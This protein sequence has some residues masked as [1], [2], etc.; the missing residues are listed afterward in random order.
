MYNYNN[1]KND[2]K[3]SGMI[4]LFSLFLVSQE[5]RSNHALALLNGT[6]AGKVNF[7]LHHADQLSV[8]DS[9]P[10]RRESITIIRKNEDKEVKMQMENG[11]IKKLEIDGKEISPDE[12]S[13]HEEIT[14]EI[15]IRT[16]RD[17]PEGEQKMFF[18][19]IDEEGMKWQ[20][21][22]DIRWDTI[23]EDF[24]LR[25]L[26][27]FQFDMKKFQDEMKMLR[28]ELNNS[29]LN[30]FFDMDTMSMDNA[31][32]MKMRFHFPDGKEMDPRDR[33]FEFS[34]PESSESPGESSFGDNMLRRN[35]NINEVLGHQLNKDGL[36]IPGKENKVELTDKN[37]KINGEKQP[38]NIWHK[39]KR[40][41][42]EET[43]T[44]LQ[45][46]SK[47]IFQFQGKESKRK[48]K[49]L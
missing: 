6:N 30:F 32:E 13:K 15:T 20:G 31:P 29:D 47:I 27:D 49:A 14:Q 45:K 34:I 10:S 16:Y 25:N 35:N 23:L 28:D 36:L 9:L 7:C 33:I 41:F 17:K 22:M 39:Y 8:S 18:F 2:N 26:K 43:G 38:S 4:I 5:T 42:E 37:L 44:T 12:Y 19:D 1:L 3:V 46:K 24:S 21:D 48:Y 40:I 11:Q